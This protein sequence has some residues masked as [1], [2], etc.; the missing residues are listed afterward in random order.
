MGF[1]IEPREREHGVGVDERMRERHA[2]LVM[3]TRRE[4]EIDVQDV[5]GKVT[6][7]Q[8]RAEALEHRR[9]RGGERVEPVDLPVDTLRLLIERR[10]RIGPKGVPIETAREVVQAQA[11]STET[12]G[13]IVAWKCRELTE[14]LDAPARER[15]GGGGVRLHHGERR[16]RERLALAPGRDDRQA[17]SEAGDDPGRRATPPIPRSP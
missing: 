11:G 5:G 17:A 4:P 8:A 16:R 15:E 2:P 3:L 12:R 9:E 6:R 10:W 14:R 13:E 7:R 1:E